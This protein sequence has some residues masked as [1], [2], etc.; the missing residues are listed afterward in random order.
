MPKEL[1]N[2][3]PTTRRYSVE[4]KAAAVRMVRTLRAELGVT[5]GTV[6][7]VATQLGYGVESVR[8]WVKQADIDDGRTSAGTG[9]RAGACRRT[10]AHQRTRAGIPHPDQDVQDRGRRRWRRHHVAGWSARRNRRCCCVAVRHPPSQGGGLTVQ[11]RAA[12]TVLAV[13]A[14]VV[15]AGLT[16]GTFTVLEP[17]KSVVAHTVAATPAANAAPT[18][19][20]STETAVPPRAGA[21]ATPQL[22]EPTLE[23][24]QT[25]TMHWSHTFEPPHTDD[26]YRGVYRIVDPAHGFCTGTGCSIY[27]AAHSRTAGNGKWAEGNDWQGLALGDTVTLAGTAYAVTER[28]V[29]AKS[30][31]ATLAGLWANEAG[32]LNLITCDETDVDARNVIVFLERTAQ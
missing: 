26:D 20:V 14:F 21:G 7:R 9:R 11:T 19:T 25:G 27:L 3:K 17:P 6:Q 31:L 16:V 24:A 4:E 8:M 28:H 5:Q 32:R 10:G 1:A 15:M 23:I 18:A 30:D 2:G 12:R 29:V 13:A 22:A